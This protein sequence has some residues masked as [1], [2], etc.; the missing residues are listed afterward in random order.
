VEAVRGPGTQMRRHEAFR[1]LDLLP[2]A[3]VGS[4]A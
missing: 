2:D 4:R 1:G 3:F